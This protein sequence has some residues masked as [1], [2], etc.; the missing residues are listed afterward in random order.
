MLC[1]R[2]WT[3]ETHIAD[4]SLIVHVREKANNALIK[5][6]KCTDEAYKADVRDS[7]YLERMSM[8]NNLCSWIKRR[9]LRF[10]GMDSAYL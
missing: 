7:I 2:I 6:V 3:D 5:T 1:S 10:T 8:V 9:R 4:G